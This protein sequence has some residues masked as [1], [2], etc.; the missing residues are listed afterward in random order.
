MYIRKFSFPNFNIEKLWTKIYLCLL[1]IRPFF[2][3]SNPFFSIKL[4]QKLPKSF[5]QLHVKNSTFFLSYFLKK[6]DW[7]KA[8]AGPRLP[9]LPLSNLSKGVKFKV[10]RRKIF[11]L[12]SAEKKKLYDCQAGAIFGPATKLAFFIFRL[13]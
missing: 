10:Q 8:Y 12:E 5:S 13:P 1:K 3:K 7:P 6:D 2:H 11:E 4:D 9:T